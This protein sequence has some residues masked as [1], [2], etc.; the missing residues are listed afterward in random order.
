M[1]SHVEKILEQRRI[2]A[3]NL[4]KKRKLEVFSKFPEFR[5]LE[6]ERENIIKNMFKDLDKVVSGQLQGPSKKRLQEL[7]DIN[8]KEQE[9]LVEKGYKKNYLELKPYCNICYDRGYL[10]NGKA[11][12][13][14]K[15][16]IIKER[17]E[18]SG[19]KKLLERENFN[20]FDIKV[21]DDKEEI[22]P[23]E[24]QKDLMQKNLDIAKKYIRNF[25]NEK[26]NL[27]FT[28]GIGTGK[29]FL[30]NCIA[31]DLIDRGVAVVYQSAG[32]LSQ[33]LTR[34]NFA[35]D[36]AKDRYVQKYDMLF[37]CDLLIIDDMG[38]EASNDYTRAFL[39]D[40]LNE[41]LQS[42]KKM[43]ISTNLDE[44]DISNIYDQRIT[45]RIFGNFDLINFFGKDI[46]MKKRY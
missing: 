3:K 2:D 20:T 45:S 33:F 7:D 40:L 24:T 21:F 19:I 32:E 22:F 26:D 30:I 14:K 35:R 13:C 43:I 6:E 39:F 28:G 27:L 5:K 38:T 8:K 9:L 36:E 25:K 44:E 16:I 17:Y 23:N 10:D 31:K 46:R 34:Y 15:Q 1:I 4:Q 41:R 37:E 18:S 42:Q 29:T 12:S 11:C